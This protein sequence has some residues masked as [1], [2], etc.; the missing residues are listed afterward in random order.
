[1]ALL[2]KTEERT[3]NSSKTTC[4]AQAQWESV[5]Q[6]KE[7]KAFIRLKMKSCARDSWKAAYTK[8]LT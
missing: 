5:G 8:H 3:H 7:K 4:K 6:K 2:S 1:M